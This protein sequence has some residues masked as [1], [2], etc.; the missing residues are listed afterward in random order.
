MPNKTFNHQ[1]NN[2]NKK[3]K[4]ISKNHEFNKY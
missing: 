4:H 2:K 1:L 3:Y